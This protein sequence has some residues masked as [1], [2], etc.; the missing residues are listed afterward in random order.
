MLERRA[1]ALNE[2]KV[3]LSSKQALRADRLALRSI[4]FAFS[5]CFYCAHMRSIPARCLP[6]PLG[7]RGIFEL[8]RIGRKM[9]LSRLGHEIAPRRLLRCF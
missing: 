7:M 4:L 3:C 2:I 5:P 8:S 6:I 1:G 9:Q